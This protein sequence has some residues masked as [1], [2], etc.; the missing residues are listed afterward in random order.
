M[1]TTDGGVQ[2]LTLLRGTLYVGGHFDHVCLTAAVGPGGKCLDGS[3][4]RFKFF[5]VTAADG[6][7]S[8]W[9]P[10]ANSPQGTY[11]LTHDAKTGRV[12]AGGAWTTFGDD[13]TD[14]AG[15]AQFR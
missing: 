1:A 14:Q 2:A 4:P 12:A 6:T 3:L 5:A 9:Q 15:F 13:T 10:Q 7:V 11:A 8:D